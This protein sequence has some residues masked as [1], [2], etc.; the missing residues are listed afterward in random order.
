MSNS[1]Y[2]INDFKIIWDKILKKW[3]KKCVNNNTKN[4]LL[5]PSIHLVSH[6]KK[7]I[8]TNNIPLIGIDILIPAQVRNFLFKIFNINKKI[9]QER[10]LK[11]LLKILLSKNNNINNKELN[12]FLKIYDLLSY[13]DNYDLL[14]NDDMKYLLKNLINILHDYNYITIQNLDNIILKK[15]QKK[16]QFWNNIFICGFNSDYWID[17]K[18]LLSVCN[19]SKNIIFCNKQECY[20][21]LESN[22]WAYT[23]KKYLFPKYMLKYSPL[24]NKYSPIDFIKHIKINNQL[25]TFLITD[26]FIN[27]AKSIIAKIIKIFKKNK[28]NSIFIGIIFKDQNSILK[29]EVSFLLNTLEISHYDIIG[30]QSPVSIDENLLYTW[31][32]FQE[33]QTIDSFLLFINFL[34]IKKKINFN[35]FFLIKKCIHRAYLKLVNNNIN[36]IINYI[37]K[38]LHEYTNLKS[39]FDFW[40]ILPNK[41]NFTLF[42]KEILKIIN[43]CNEQKVINLIQKLNTFKFNKF[44]ILNTNILL[45]W[46]KDNLK[47]KLTQKKFGSYHYAKIY[48]LTSKEA[49]HYNWTH[50]FLTETNSIIFN[51]KYSSYINN[52]INI[53]NNENLWHTNSSLLSSYDHQQEILKSHIL[54][55]VNQKKIELI[56]TSSN[57]IIDNSN[58]IFYI[59]YFISK[60]EHLKDQNIKIIQS[61]TNHIINKYFN[62]YIKKQHIKDNFI[63]AFNDKINQN[64]PF[65]VYN[66]CLKNKNKPIGKISCKELEKI[67]HYPELTFIN[68]LLN[69]NKKIYYNHLN[70]TKMIIGIWVHEWLN[71]FF[72]KKTNITDIVNNSIEE[73]KNIFL[74]IPHYWQ[75]IWQKSKNIFLDLLNSVNNFTKNNKIYKYK[76][77]ELKINNHFFLKNKKIYLKGNIDLIMS[78]NPL[79]VKKDNKI[80]IIDFKTGKDKKL[81]NIQLSYYY[82]LQLIFYGIGIFTDTNI[83]MEN[84]DLAI[85][86]PGDKLTLQIN[87]KKILE[88]NNISKILYELKNILY[89]KSFGQKG[90]IPIKYNNNQLDI[91]V[92]KYPL[93][94][95]PIKKNIIL[96][97]ESLTKKIN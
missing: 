48:L 5:V 19:L 47:I 54:Y 12:I 70:L 96:K 93:A 94:M 46:L 57:L 37:H 82:G 78:K 85:L 18:I 81:S 76:Y 55:L 4:L 66:F 75:D 26:S 43:I 32:D 74:D 89:N 80:L 34:F 41:I 10:D 58:L 77:S 51:R 21:I 68:K 67:F 52:F 95:I 29:K 36:Y 63:L 20:Q 23:W 15:S 2:E 87:L 73:V 45:S 53:L 72:I 27:E 64:T 11:F 25:T 9:I 22:F 8:V 28:H 50:I 31:I 39:I 3:I 62:N 97:K 86:K 13:N 14:L 7:I 56:L 30:S 49:I 92:N 91:N 84:I 16:I 83:N 69:I 90:P 42:K 88:N 1:Y 79:D 17:Y 24:L 61:K 71:I 40:I 65:G 35:S 60:K 6:I 44:L 38:Y 33:K 59:I